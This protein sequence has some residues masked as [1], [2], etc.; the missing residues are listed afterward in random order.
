MVAQI[1]TTKNRDW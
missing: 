1:I